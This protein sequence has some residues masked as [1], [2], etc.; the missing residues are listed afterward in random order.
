MFGAP[1]TLRLTETSLSRAIGIELR[2]IGPPRGSLA[3]SAMGYSG[4]KGDLPS[5]SV[6][7][8]RLQ[9]LP[10][11]ATA[12]AVDAAMLEPPT[13]QAPDARDL[14]DFTIFSNAVAIRDR[15]SL[16][17][18]RIAPV[19]PPGMVLNY[20]PVQRR[21]RFVEALNAVAD[22]AGFDEF[23]RVL[24]A[25]GGVHG[26]LTAVGADGRASGAGTRPPRPV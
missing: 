22:D 21:A 15:I 16:E 24:T 20:P 5:R 7:L 1:E 4:P 8:A 9:G 19:W 18:A 14:V 3:L 11:G 23:A 2:R 17:L 6:V 25:H 13:G 12:A 10:R 26:R